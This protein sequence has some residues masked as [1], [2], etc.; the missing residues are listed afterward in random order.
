MRILGD[1]AAA[2]RRAPTVPPSPPRPLQIGRARS[3]CLASWLE[4]SIT[5]SPILEL[6]SLLKLVEFLS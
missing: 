6:E 4:T 1:D 2:A 5:R 3:L